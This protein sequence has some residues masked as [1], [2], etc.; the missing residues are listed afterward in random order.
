MWDWTRD[1]A[2]DIAEDDWRTIKHMVIARLQKKVDGPQSKSV[3]FDVPTNCTDEEFI[4]ACTSTFE[5][6]VRW[7]VDALSK[8][9]VVH[10]GLGFLET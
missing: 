10:D 2:V 5:I 9:S 3:P 7:G 6:A 8:P 4:T 1:G